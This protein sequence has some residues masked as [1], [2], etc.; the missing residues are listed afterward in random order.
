MHGA[1]R[2]T[3][4]LSRALAACTASLICATV[5]ACSAVVD[6][7]AI[8]DAQTAARVKTALVNDPE[9]GV[10]EI[11]VRVERHIVQLAGRVRAQTDA[12]RAA[13]VARSVPGVQGVELALQVSVEAP[14]ELP[15]P[16]ARSRSAPADNRPEIEADP[17]LLAVGVSA[18]L[19]YPRSPAL[20]PRVAISPVIKLGSGEGLGVAVGFDWFQAEARLAA[21]GPAAMTRIHV[22][23][24]MVGLSYTLN[25]D[26]VSLSPSIVAGYAFNSLSVTDTGAVAGLPVEVDNSLA[27]RIGASAWFDVSRRF[28][29]NVSGGYL[30]TRLRLTVLE[31]SSLVKQDQRGDTVIA[32][33][34]LAYRLF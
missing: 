24:V 7:A 31:D 30:I 26:R 16:R 15:D 18:G 25:S 20:E 17:G 32:H 34:G 28:A 2:S 12:D 13:A 4:C 3:R 5:P 9:L 6:R 22:K 29:L 21:S 11:D 19:S 10:S 14:A 23:P 1:V 27:W 8:E 33:V